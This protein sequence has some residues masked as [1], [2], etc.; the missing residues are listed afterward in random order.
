MP[1]TPAV[2]KISPALTVPPSALTVNWL[3][4]WLAPLTVAVVML[5]VVWLTTLW[6]SKKRKPRASYIMPVLYW[7]E[8]D[9]TGLNRPRN[10]CCTLVSERGASTTLR[11]FIWPKFGA[12]F[13]LSTARAIATGV[14]LTLRTLLL[15]STLATA[16]RMPGAMFAM[17]W[18]ATLLASALTRGRT[19]RSI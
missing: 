7:R 13:S 14:S 4:L 8:I 11:I 15:A 1:L 10:D 9:S 19:M 5:P 2:E 17:I 16:L 18:I 3:P 6:S 12:E